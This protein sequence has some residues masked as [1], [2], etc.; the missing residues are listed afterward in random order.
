MFSLQVCVNPMR[1][2]SKDCTFAFPFFPSVPHIAASCEM[3]VEDFFFGPLG[4]AVGRSTCPD[5][6]D[7]LQQCWCG[8]GFVHLCGVRRTDGAARCYP[9][10][11]VERGDTGAL[12]PRRRVVLR[13]QRCCMVEFSCLGT[14]FGYMCKQLLPT[15][16]RKK[17]DS[18]RSGRF[19]YFHQGPISTRALLRASRPPSLRC[20]CTLPTPPTSPNTCRCSPDSRWIATPR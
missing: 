6:V 7:L 3:A 17:V 11:Q 5:T 4:Q 16:Y 18:H 13:R 20:L 19:W 10:R 12:E 8:R 9:T 15:G 14:A 1:M 2:V